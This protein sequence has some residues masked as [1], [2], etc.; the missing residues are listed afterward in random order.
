MCE[1]CHE[2]GEGKKWYLQAKNYSQELINDERRQFTGDFLEKI[3]ENAVSGYT[4]LDKLM[5][6][7][8]AAAKAAMA[9]GEGERKRNHWGQVVP[10]EEIEQI[11]DMNVSVVRFPC[12]CRSVLGGVYD[13]RYCFGTAVFEQGSALITQYPDWSTDLE[14]LTAEEA[15]KKIRKLDS[16]GL[17][18]TVWTMITPYIGGIC[19]C[20]VN[21]CMAMKMGLRYGDRGDRGFFKAEYVATIDWESCS[22]CRDCMKLC[23]FGAISYSPLVEKCYISQFE[24][25]G[26]GVCRALCPRDAI[27]LKDRNAIPVLA[28]DW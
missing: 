21:D 8:P 1:F 11:L 27:T 2:H 19:N 4:E 24:C 3:E 10:L 5:V 26:C 16:K 17:V 18:H 14:V 15:K 25:Y 28:N 9:S 23:N 20:N 7:D 13:A 6:S 22:G 12:V